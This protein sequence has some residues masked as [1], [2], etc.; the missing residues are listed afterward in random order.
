[1]PTYLYTEKCM[2]IANTP[3]ERLYFWVA[4]YF[5]FWANIS[6][7]R[8]H[9]KVIAITGSTGKTT[10][11]Q[12][13]DAQLSGKAHFSHDANSIYG[14]SFDILGL[15]GVTSSRSE[16]LKLAFVAPW[17][18]LTFTRHEPYYVVEIDGA[19]PNGASILAGWLK[20]NI[21]ALT[22]I[23]ESHAV[24]FDPQVKSGI[25][26]T[27]LDA[28]TDEFMSLPRN[29]SHTLIVADSDEIIAMAIEKNKTKLPTETIKLQKSAFLTRYDVRLEG[30]DFVFPSGTYAFSY[31]LP[32]EVWLQLAMSEEIL[33]LLNIP[34]LTHDFRT[35]R[36]PAG[37]S[38]VLNGIKDTRIV[39]S[40]YNAQ[41]GSMIATLKMFQQMP[42]EH[43]W[44]VI[45]DIIEL[46]TSE[47]EQHQKLGEFLADYPA[48]K[49]ILVGKR[50]K[51]DTAP[52]LT[53][54]NLITCDDAH[55]ALDVLKT[56]LQGN[57]MILFKG[58]QHLEWVISKLLA[59]PK[60]V[61]KLSRQ[62]P[63]DYARRK[64]LGYE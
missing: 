12:I 7:K 35:L 56:N 10:L 14:I 6:L 20:P 63:A 51:R 38:T 37:R 46:G 36:L 31:P 9:P 25:Y 60:D 16:W 26:Q 58:S 11:L 24:F 34:I 47:R 17:R 59:K 21:T 42:G 1:M 4:K 62:S 23:E 43:K 8:W 15:R 29:T 55:H 45:G 39:D 5:R 50:L 53:K 32:E 41:L 18:A 2:N 61:S 27:H 40:S 22:N 30:T 19:R 13:L 54:E 28:I 49:I 48:E 64:K 3:K 52:L 44:V 33:R 57:E